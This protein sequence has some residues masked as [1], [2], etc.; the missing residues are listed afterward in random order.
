[1]SA[2]LI[3]YASTHGHTAKIASRIADVLRAQG[4]TVDVHDDVAA[5]DP[6][7]CDYDAVVA[8]GSIHAGH[9]QAELVAW[10]L[11]HGTALN[12]VPSACFSVCLAAAE[13]SN[14]ARATTRGYLDDLED[15]T[16]WT[17]RRRIAFPGALQYREYDFVTRLV[18]RVLAQR[19]HHATDATQDVD[20][21]DWDAVDAFAHD[22]AALVA[23]VAVSR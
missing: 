1:M 17:P 6:R 13:D 20:Y 4:H 22:C 21:T 15:A 16:G 23:P 12:V 5:T 10:A 3:A 14:E 7:P 9:H 2:F 19:H 8:G 18:M 11:R